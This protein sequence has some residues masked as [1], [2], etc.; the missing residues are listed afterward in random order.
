MADSSAWV[1]EHLQS[2][3]ENVSLALEHDMPVTLQ[4]RNR[5]NANWTTKNYTPGPRGHHFRIRPDVSAD[6]GCLVR[7]VEIIIQALM[8]NV[9]IT[10]R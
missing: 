9:I 2:M 5:H 4:L 8:N 7:V 1:R 10:K 3:L 6:I